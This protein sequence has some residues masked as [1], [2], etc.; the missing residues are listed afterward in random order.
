[1]PGKLDPVVT[2][3]ASPKGG[4]GKTTITANLAAALARQGQRVLVVD[5]DPQNAL[6]LHFEMPLDDQRGLV[7]PTLNDSRW[8]DSVFRSPFDV[9]CLAY[10]SC[11]EAERIRLE[12]TLAQDADFLADE[13]RHIVTD[14]GGYDHIVIDTPPGPSIYMQRAMQ[15]ADLSLLV[16]LADAA[17]FATIPKMESLAREYCGRDR[18]AMYYLVNQMDGHKL[19]KRDVEG[20]LQQ[21]LKNRMVPVSVHYDSA[22]EEALACNQ[23]VLEYAGYAAASQDIDR[24]AQWLN[25]LA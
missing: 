16:L 20:L 22:V 2:V 5:L 15:A 10:G 25:E 12:T 1:M 13:L 18:P 4:V 8:R 14:A 11:S 6:R 24:V 23:P 21:S 19:L 3:V 9:D 7:T 17:S